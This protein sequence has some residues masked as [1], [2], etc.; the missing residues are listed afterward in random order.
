M[1]VTREQV[2]SLKRAFEAGATVEEASELVTEHMVRPITLRARRK[3]SEIRLSNCSP[4][5]KGSVTIMLLLPSSA[6]ITKNLSNSLPAR[7][8][9]LYPDTLTD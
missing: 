2:L 3:K 5:R 6:R 7:L 4:P 8:C 1:G 9:P